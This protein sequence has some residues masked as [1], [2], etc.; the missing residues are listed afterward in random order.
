MTVCV[1]THIGMPIA[2]LISQETGA[3]LND[4]QIE[5]LNF[6]QTISSELYKGYVDDEF[7]CCW[8]LVPPTVFSTQAYLW[9]YTS[10]AVAKHQFL[11]VRR[12]Q[13]IVEDMLSRYDSLIGHCVAN[14][15]TSRRWLRWL[16][17]Q[18]GPQVGD[19]VPFIIRRRLHG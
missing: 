10:E 19:L 15:R 16:G 13:I 12:S 2:A 9:M 18:F 1:A 11:F 5:V 14:S 8:G 3:K 6:C 17:A 4:R 7:V